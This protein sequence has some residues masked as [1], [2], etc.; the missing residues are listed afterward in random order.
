MNE[1]YNTKI[2]KNQTN[3]KQL[4]YEIELM[5]KMIVLIELTKNREIIVKILV[6]I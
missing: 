4:K 3:N 2:N 6:N 1:L 5:D